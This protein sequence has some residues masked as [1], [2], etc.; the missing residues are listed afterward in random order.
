MDNF[1]SP[2]RSEAEMGV[3]GQTQP[4]QVGDWTAGWRV[5]IADRINRLNVDLTRAL[6]DADLTKVREGIG[7]ARSAARLDGQGLS[8]FEWLGQWVTGSAVES[9]WRGL[10]RAEE[11]FML[12]ADDE[13][14]IARLNQTQDTLRALGLT[15]QALTDAQMAVMEMKSGAVDKS[16]LRATLE[17]LNLS[18]DGYH[19]ELRTLRNILFTTT[20]LLFVGLAAMAI[21]GWLAPQEFSLC[22]V[23]A[24]KGCNSPSVLEVEIAGGFGGLLSAVVFITNLPSQNTPY[25]IWLY[26]GL[27][28]APTGA[29]LALI[30][31]FL[32]QTGL[33]GFLK[34][35]TEY[36]IPYALVFGFAQQA[37]TQVV[38]NWATGIVKRSAPAK[39]KGSAAKPK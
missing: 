10:H 33:V 26:Q 28:K 8:P 20:M 5:L 27:L 9:A 23:P 7:Q 31:V 21:V 16:T 34:A 24:P 3:T 11:E 15:G 4:I 1:N 19:S 2:L 32:V 30:V 25:T 17:G 12:V 14:V 13:W 36:V 37:A 29:A 38:D 18:S 35:N 6:H 39:A 22:G